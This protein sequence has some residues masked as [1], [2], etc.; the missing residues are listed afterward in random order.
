[1]NTVEFAKSQEFVNFLKRTSCII[2][3]QD[4]GDYVIDI[5]SVINFTYLDKMEIGYDISGKV[6]GGT[7]NCATFCRYVLD[8]S[9]K[10]SVDLKGFD[11]PIKMLEVSREEE[12]CCSVSFCIVFPM[13]EFQ[14]INSIFSM[15]EK[16][17]IDI[18]KIERW[19][20]LDI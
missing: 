13:A 16:K 3:F 9:I 10:C 20:F 6:C 18:K 12:G 7:V 11:Y 4:R 17:K 2:S 19:E 1:M 8:G 5:E 14:R 15:F